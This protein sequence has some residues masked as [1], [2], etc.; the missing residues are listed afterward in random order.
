MLC[1]CIDTNWV[2]LLLLQVGV[3]GPFRTLA[4]KHIPWSHRLKYPEYRHNM[5]EHYKPN[6][7]PNSQVPTESIPSPKEN[8]N[9]QQQQDT[10][11]STQ[12]I[13]IVKNDLEP[14]KKEKPKRK[15]LSLKLSKKMFLKED[16]S[17]DNKCENLCPNEENSKTNSFST[18]K[19]SSWNSDY[20]KTFV[21]KICS[22]VY[23]DKR[24]MLSH[25]KNHESLIMSHSNI[26][27]SHLDIAINKIDKTPNITGKSKYV[28]FSEDKVLKSEHALYY[29][30]Y[31]A[32]VKR[33]RSPSSSSDDDVVGRK[34]KYK[35]QRFISE[36]SNT[37]AT[38][39][40]IEGNITSADVEIEDEKSETNDK[41]DKDEKISD[42]NVEC[43]NINVDETS[44]ESSKE[45]TSSKE[46]PAKKTPQRNKMTIS[47][48]IT[49]CQNKYLN[50]HDTSKNVSKL[51]ENMESFLQHKFLSIG[52]KIVHKGL[53]ST[54]LLRYLE[55][56]DLDINWLQSKNSLSNII[57]K[58]KLK[59]TNTVSNT[60][61]LAL[62]NITDYIIDHPTRD[63]VDDF[64]NVL[65]EKETPARKDP[66]DAS[67]SSSTVIVLNDD[68]TDK[69]INSN[70]TSK[71]KT[72]LSSNKETENEG[73][74]VLV[75]RS[76][77]ETDRQNCTK[78]LNA[79]PV[80]NP[81]QL[82]NKKSNT[83][84]PTETVSAVD[85]ILFN[86]NNDESK[87][88]V[89]TSTV[90]LANYDHA[91][92]R[93]KNSPPRP[94]NPQKTGSE[95][96]KP[97]IKVKPVSELMPIQNKQKP[98]DPVVQTGWT[99]TSFV[100]IAPNPSQVYVSQYR[101]S[102]PAKVLSYPQTFGSVQNNRIDIP[103]SNAL[104]RNNVPTR[105]TQEYVNMHTVELPNTKTNSPFKYFKE[106][107]QIHNIVLL[108]S[109][110]IVPH[111]MKCIIKFTLGFQQENNA[112]VSL[113]LTLFYDGN[114]FCIKVADM[115]LKEIDISKLSANWQWEI[116]KVFKSDIVNKLHTNALKHGLHINAKV[117]YFVSLLRSIVFTK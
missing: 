74:A 105:V 33:A 96:N 62:K 91:K 64:E 51:Q 16:E 12:Q 117:N 55:H 27:N 54:G 31:I 106:L 32:K 66:G 80:A 35:R 11:S 94:E 76:T 71:L 107:L 104:S 67:P 10:V 6:N 100:P 109:T 17:L 59:D 50:R 5:Q 113:S 20:F 73:E 3:I 111:T 108:D 61:N 97:W 75:L 30:V 84:M 68:Q 9:I 115:A 44:K 72:I 90:S 24:D 41:N 99:P 49:G 8:N 53:N 60:D 88:P 23:K 18:K 86:Y 47:D 112:P 102:E 39:E 70:V 110:A 56:K 38:T 26:L 92:P 114:I 95:T 65:G 78:I 82:P 101:P 79:N 93:E 37:S 46:K 15:S 81:K 77:Q 13:D 21:C 34:S 2:N 45:T 40:V 48:I 36:D 116:L 85:D 69:Y 14:S 29:I 28:V 58:T 52:T 98:S 63:F 43:V 42:E 103:E 22:K 25:M 83:P 89:I 19:R 4:Y 57:I 7:Q 1:S 87:M